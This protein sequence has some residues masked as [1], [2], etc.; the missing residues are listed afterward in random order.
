L[1]ATRVIHQKVQ[2]SQIYLQIDTQRGLGSGA[3]GEGRTSLADQPRNLIAG[4]DAAGYPKDQVFGRSYQAGRHDMP[5]LASAVRPSFEAAHDHSADARAE[6]NIDAAR[7]E[8]KLVP[9]RSRV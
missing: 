4:S 5:Y 7:T 1:T 6:L 8:R 9:D 3:T 2:L